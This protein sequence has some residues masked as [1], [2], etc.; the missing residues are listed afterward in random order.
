MRGFGTVS[1]GTVVSGRLAVGDE[2][3]IMPEGRLARV[4]GLQVH[5]QGV[6]SV[7]AG[8]RAAVNLSGLDTAEVPRGA[9]IAR[10]GELRATWLLDGEAALLAEVAPLEDG[11]RVR[12][13]V[14]SAEVL[15]RVR[16]L[17]EDRVDP[18]GPSLIQL[19]LERPVVA[20]RGDRLILRAY[21]PVATIGGARVL[22]PLPP[23]R[24]RAGREAV[25]RL[26]AAGDDLGT[27]AACHVAE[28]GTA[29]LAS[30]ELAARLSV[31]EA[32][33]RPLVASRPDLVELGQTA[34]SYLSREALLGL[35][36]AALEALDAFHRQQPLRASMPREELKER[37][38]ARAPEDAFAYVLGDLAAAGAIRIDP[39]AVA[40][41]EHRVQLDPGEA[42]A[43]ELLLKEALDSGLAGIVLAE[44]AERCRQ[45]RRRL[46]RVARVLGEEGLLLRVG[47]SFLVHRE[48]LEA[49]K[50]EVRRRWAPGAR[51]DVAEFKDLTGLTRKFVIPLLEFLDRER[52]TR[53]A[54]NDRQVLA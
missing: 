31:R 21:S 5:G 30:T 33:L 17:G 10:P 9:V 42:E 41:T 49:L 35:G 1:T 54:G 14:G 27:L 6:E 15:G 2:V 22:D 52:V 37:V 20:G 8:S 16:V 13:H 29:G 47:A 45:D 7:P 39:S 40:R 12:V 50:A 36:A 32:A 3:Q 48:R 18:A 43:R 34:R 51:V 38:F 4:R 44:L 26:R 19:R 11:T 25:A 28:A 23:K 24:R 46:E 53:R